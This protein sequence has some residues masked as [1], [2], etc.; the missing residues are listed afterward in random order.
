MYIDAKHYYETTKNGKFVTKNGEL[1]RRKDIEKEEPTHL[2]H[3]KRPTNKLN[4]FKDL[5]HR[6]IRDN[7]DSSEFNLFFFYSYTEWPT[8]SEISHLK[9]KNPKDSKEDKISEQVWLAE[10]T[11]Q[12]FL[13]LG[14]W[15]GMNIYN[16]ILQN[17]ISLGK[18]F[19]RAIETIENTAREIQNNLPSAL[20]NY[21][22]RYERGYETFKGVLYNLDKSNDT[23]VKRLGKFQNAVNDFESL[24]L[25]I[26]Y[27][28]I[29][30]LT[31]HNSIKSSSSNTVNKNI[32][33]LQ[34]Q[35]KAGQLQREPLSKKAQGL[36]TLGDYRQ[37]AKDPHF[38]LSLFPEG[39][40]TSPYHAIKI[41]LACSKCLI[42]YSRENISDKDR[43]WFNIHFPGTKYHTKNPELLYCI[44]LME[45]A[46]RY[47]KG[48]SIDELYPD[49]NW[50]KHADPN[51]SFFT[52]SGYSY[53]EV[54][55]HLVHK[56]G[57]DIMFF[58]TD[59]YLDGTKESSISPPTSIF[60]NKSH[61]LDDLKINPEPDIIIKTWLANSLKWMQS[62]YPE[63]EYS[64]HRVKTEF[65]SIE[66]QLE[67]EWNRWKRPQENKMEIA[68][69]RPKL[70]KTA[71][72]I[73]EKLLT[74]PEHRAMQLPEIVVWLW[75]EHKI[76]LTDSTVHQ[77]HLKKLEPWGL[78]HDK[79]IGYSII[80]NKK[81]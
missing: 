11:Y 5:R 71:S 23:V 48:Q 6:I 29:R 26:H 40:N 76:N 55:F 46:I 60:L 53:L 81:V 18:P 25:T 20:P 37:A 33:K 30:I 17:L 58:L 80:Q 8:L 27:K 12:V 35:G 61:I 68:K 59:T 4:W 31:R 67:H 73:Y 21:E 69:N 2:P 38:D 41:A 15:G 57:S 75:E 24:I 72:F 54:G 22:S 16:E 51:I 10:A 78:Q 49:P 39:K 34:S 45:F 28:I 9:I 3:Q 66:K 74:L 63:S 56:M 43:G 42:D 44:E 36:Q 62:D 70:G 77:K 50:P 7:A 64:R 14:D 52:F 47:R 65:N 32:S 79:R 19:T 1:V 13:K